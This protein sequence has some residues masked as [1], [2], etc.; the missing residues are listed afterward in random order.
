MII[1]PL[2]LVAPGPTHT[3]DFGEQ[4]SGGFGDDQPTKPRDL[5]SDLPKSLD[6]RRAAPTDHLVRET[7]FYDGWQGVCPPPIFISPFPG[8]P[9]RVY[10]AS[11][12]PMPH[13]D[14]PNSCPPQC[15]QSPC[16]S[17]T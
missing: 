14:N 3:M 2:S 6:D 7:E 12:D 8:G 4:D 5:P 1:S 13:Q 17:A 9:G 16:S 11:A 15:W 10:A